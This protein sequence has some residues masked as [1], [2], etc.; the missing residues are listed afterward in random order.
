MPGNSV[1]LFTEESLSILDEDFGL[2]STMDYSAVFPDQVLRKMKCVE[3]DLTK[4]YRGFLIAFTNSGANFPDAILSNN[5]YEGRNQQEHET[6]W[7]A[8]F[9]I[10]EQGQLIRVGGLASSL[11]LRRERVTAMLECAREKI[12]VSEPKG[13]LLLFHNWQCIRVYVD[14]DLRNINKIHL[15]PLPGFDEFKFPFVACC[16][17]ESITLVNLNEDYMGTLIKSR[18]ASKRGQRAFFFRREAYGLSLHF[19]Q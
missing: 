1:I 2:V 13:S 18:T 7:I 14:D 4:D 12:L 17:R 9:T 6:S 10:D 11:L 19:V 8:R 15:C 5:V 16:G 3:P